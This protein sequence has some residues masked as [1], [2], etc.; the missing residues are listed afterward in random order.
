VPNPWKGD[1]QKKTVQLDPKEGPRGK[2]TIKRETKETE[3]PK[4]AEPEAAKP[5]EAK[6][7]PTFTDEQFIAALKEIGK[8][9]S[10]REISDALGIKDADKGRALVRRVMAKLTKEGKVK[11]T[12][13]EKGRAAKL[14]SLV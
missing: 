4:T 11:V 2:A 13:A 9:T 14:C 3:K 8:P 5:T 10:S 6:G 12:E 1:Q 7:K